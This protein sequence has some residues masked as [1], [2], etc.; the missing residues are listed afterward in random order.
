MA[1]KRQPPGPMAWAGMTGAFGN[2]KAPPARSA[3]LRGLM[4][5]RLSHFAPG[6]GH[7]AKSFSRYQFVDVRADQSAPT[8]GPVESWCLP[9]LL[10]DVTALA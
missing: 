2:A 9:T 7:R 1:G 5:R 6:M 3:H 4:M 10:A 8:A